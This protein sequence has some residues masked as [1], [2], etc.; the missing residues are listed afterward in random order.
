MGAAAEDLTEPSALDECCC[1]PIFRR[2]SKRLKQVKHIVCFLY[3][4]MFFSPQ[5][6][7]KLEMS[8]KYILK[9][10]F[11][12]STRRHMITFYNKMTMLH[13]IFLQ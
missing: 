4:T 3:L 2:E 6:Y 12:T 5:I 10:L 13:N 1:G 9:S 7:Q 8:G 11:C